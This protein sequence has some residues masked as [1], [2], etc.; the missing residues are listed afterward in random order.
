MPTSERYGIGFGEVSGGQS[1]G[2]PYLPDTMDMPMNAA[3]TLRDFLLTFTMWVVMMIVMMTPVATPLLLVFT[4]SRHQTGN[5]RLSSAIT[6]GAGHLTV[7]MGFSLVAALFQGVLH[8]GALLSP[9]MSIRSSLISGVIL[10][11]VGIYQLTPLKS[12]CLTKCQ[13]PVDF[14][15]AHWKEGASGALRLGVL[16][17]MYCL[18]CCWALM[19]VLF[20]VGVMNYA[21]IAVLTA[22]VLLEKFGPYG[23]RVA[24]LAG[25]ALIVAGAV[26]AMSS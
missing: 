22:F 24:R 18:G 14:M 10:I 15:M 20:V 21:W 19:F 6:F 9:A 17:G 23:L 2:V 11:V 12:K 3:W 7:W 13:S 8:S 5:R 25:I 1:P 16:H 4:R 26:T